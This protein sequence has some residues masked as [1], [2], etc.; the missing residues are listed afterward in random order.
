MSISVAVTVPSCLNWRSVILKRIFS[1][2]INWLA[3]SRRLA[4]KLPRL[5]TSAFS[6]S[7]SLTPFAICSPKNQLK[8]FIYSFLIPGRKGGTI[9]AA[10]S[11]MTSSIRSTVR[12]NELG[13]C[14]S[15]PTNAIIL[16]KSSGRREGIRV[17]QLSI[18]KMVATPKQREG[19]SIFPR[20]SLKNAFANRARK[21]IDCRC[22]KFRP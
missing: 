19:G 3:A 5:I 12:L 14:E 11:R 4:G 2:S 18:L 20:R 21:F 15:R 9:D 16:I 7:K 17:L 8:H 10:L 22:E 1:A 13:P 6:M